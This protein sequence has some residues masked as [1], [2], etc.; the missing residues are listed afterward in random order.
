MDKGTWQATVHGVAKSRTRLSNCHS[1]THTTLHFFVNL[2]LKGSKLG[3]YSFFF[4]CYV[5]KNLVLPCCV[6]LFYEFAL[7]LTQSTSFLIFLVTKHM[8]VFP[9]DSKQ[10]S[11]TLTGHPTIE[12]SSGTLYPERPRSSSRSPGIL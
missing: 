9:H 12:L 6:F 8:E 11:A 1:L 2:F 4:P 5:G 7:P 3:K 10:S